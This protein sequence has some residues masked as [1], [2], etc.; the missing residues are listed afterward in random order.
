MYQQ[1]VSEAVVGPALPNDRPPGLVVDAQNQQF[2]WVALVV[3]AK[4]RNGPTPY[5]RARA[6]P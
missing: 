3:D 4:G 2:V 5:K 1:V 6:E